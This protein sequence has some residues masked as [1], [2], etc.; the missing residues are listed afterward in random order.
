MESGY[1]GGVSNET[2]IS[3]KISGLNTEPVNDLWVFL[4]WVEW[5]MQF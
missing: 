2:G 5:L 3:L 4:P 1:A